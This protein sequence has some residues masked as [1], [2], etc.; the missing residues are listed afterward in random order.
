MK[1]Q[2]T[3]SGS[4]KSLLQS[5]KAAMF[6][7]A[8]VTIFFASAACLWLTSRGEAQ[9]FD[10][11][12]KD[13]EGLIGKPIHVDFFKGPDVDGTISAVAKATGRLPAFENL[14]V[15]VRNRGRRIKPEQIKQIQV[16]GQSFAVQR[17][18]PSGQSVLIN[19]S[20]AS[21]AVDDRLSKINRTRRSGI[22]ADE[23][24]KLS[25]ENLEFA[26][27]SMAKISGSLTGRP[28]E[29][30]NVILISDYPE[31]QQRL[32]VSTLDA[33]IPKLNLIFG[34]TTDEHVLPGKPIVGAF[35][36]RSSL[37]AFQ[38]KVVGNPDFGTIRAFFQVVEAHIVVTAEDDRSPPHMTWQVAWGLSGAFSTYSYSDVDLPAWV[39]V[40]LQQLC[41]D[42]LVPRVAE[43][44]NERRSVLQEL[45]TGSLNGIL[46]AENLP[47][48]RQIVCKALMAHLYALNAGAF[49]QLI[50]LLKSGRPTEDALM[51]SYGLEIPS[52]AAS[53]GRSLGINGLQP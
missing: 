37:G 10:G 49:G 20:T 29:G 14:E 12:V 44:A 36:S 33:F 5:A 13:I 34:Y 18:F 45:K 42:I 30:T 11:M 53:F 43:A 51:L 16:D 24:E 31:S 38:S 32:L 7:F 46:A 19:Q 6:T 35:S 52:L 21:E 22:S 4:W 26:K 47:G 1:T 25:A 23:F 27:A 28:V 41:S 17:H 8:P 39:R 48:E 50:S 15:N 3:V 2:L 40:G 9:E